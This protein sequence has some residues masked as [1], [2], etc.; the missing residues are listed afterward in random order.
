MRIDVG[1]RD[2]K[3][4]D[5]TQHLAATAQEKLGGLIEDVVGTRFFGKIGVALILQAGQITEIQPI[6]EQRIR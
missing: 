1:E 4:L 3:P 5:N 2:A 6:V